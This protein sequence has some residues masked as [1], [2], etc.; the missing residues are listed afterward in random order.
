MSQVVILTKNPY[1]T[2][3]MTVLSSLHIWAKPYEL[4]ANIYVNI[5][6]KV[7]MINYTMYKCFIIAMHVSNVMVK[8]L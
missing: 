2:A 8:F 1:P 4:T 7:L 3:I 5:K 6:N